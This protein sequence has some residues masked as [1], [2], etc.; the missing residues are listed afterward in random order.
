MYDINIKEIIEYL[1]TQLK[2]IVGFTSITAITAIIISL[3]LGEVYRS[4]ALIKISESDFQSGSKVSSSMGGLAAL[5]GVD[6]PTSGTGS[7]KTPAY[8]VAKIKSRS[9]FK[10][11]SSFPGILEGVFAGKAFDRS[12]GKMIYDESLYDSINKKW[13]RKHSG[14]KEPKPSYL[15]AHIIFLNNIGI[16]ADKRTDFI[17]IVYDHSSPYFAKE[18]IELIVRELNNIQMTEDLTQTEK[19][20]AYL[21]NIQSK[22]NKVSIDK[23]LSLLIEGQ[24]QKQMLASIDDEYLI[25][26]IDQP[27]VPES[28]I[29]PKKSIIVI[30]STILSFIFILVL[31]IFYKFIYLNKDQEILHGFTE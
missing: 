28:R 27:I 7:R 16:L 30:A 10:H 21:S 22:N 8:A 11:I 4:E 15:E 23:S 31:L 6:L 1:V 17:T 29:F 3:N 12:N 2:V 25:E 26:Y 13:I 5:A 14:S 24:I 9:F 19:A 18:L 20:L